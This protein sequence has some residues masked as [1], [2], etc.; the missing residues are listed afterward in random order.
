MH[1]RTFLT[2]T[3]A[4]P[5]LTS[6]S[7]LFARSPGVFNT[8]GIAVH[9][10][11]VVAYFTMGQAMQGDSEQAV[12]WGGAMWYFASDEH[13][14]AFEMNPRGYCPCYG[15]Y[16]AYAM[17]QGQVAT[18]VPEAWTLAGGKL[19]L[20]YSTDVRTLWRRDVPGNVARADGF[21]P[22]ALG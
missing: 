12:K 15:G 14:I 18:T 9:G 13:R 7:A 10:Y 16:C 2:A 8:G 22:G 20:N 1:R 17:A 6:G 4:L 19:Y 3:L 5:V 11:D 21:W